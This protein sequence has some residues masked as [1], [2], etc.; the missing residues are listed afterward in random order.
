MPWSYDLAPGSDEFARLRS[1]AIDKQLAMFEEAYPDNLLTSFWAKGL[2]EVM[3][4]AVAQAHTQNS[5]YAIV[6]SIAN[7]ILGDEEQYMALAGLLDTFEAHYTF[8][9]TYTAL[10]PAG[11]SKALNE[12]LPHTQVLFNLDD[13]PAGS[14]LAF[15]PID[16]KVYLVA[17]TAIPGVRLI[18]DGNMTG[19]LASQVIRP[20]LL[21]NVKDSD[22]ACISMKFSR[23]VPWT[24]LFHRPFHF[25]DQSAGTDFELPYWANSM[26]PQVT[27][28]QVRADALLSNHD[29]RIDAIET[30]A[31]ITLQ[32]ALAVEGG[33]IQPLVMPG[34]LLSSAK[35]I[36]GTLRLRP[37]ELMHYEEALADVVSLLELMATTPRESAQIVDALHVSQVK[38]R[39]LA[40]S[41]RRTWHLPPTSFTSRVQTLFDR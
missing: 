30:A 38:I 9:R 4:H 14:L 17:E 35:F 33:N 18:L 19:E 20:S 3:S 26:E 7:A 41:I 10:S 1:N 36:S 8:G 6:P 15:N 37:S 11:I 27:P 34:K 2:S 5:R 22:E 25:Y 39:L 29:D 40:H 24:E 16:E 31:N 28:A 32:Y 13:M 12:D 21:I 23:K